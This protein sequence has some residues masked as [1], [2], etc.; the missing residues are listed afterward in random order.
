M[1]RQPYFSGNYGSALGQIDTRPI[2]QGAAAQAA[3][4]QGL[5]QNI[6]GAIEKYQL[7]KQKADTADMMIGAYLQNMSPADRGE[8]EAG[9]SEIGK[10]LNKFIDGELPTSKKVA[11]A[12][13]LGVMQAQAKTAADIRE[14]EAKAAYYEGGGARTPVDPEKAMKVDILQGLRDR[15]NAPR[16]RGQ[17][18]RGAQAPPGA[19]GI[20]GPGTGSQPL[21]VDLN[22]LIASGTQRALG[23]TPGGGPGAP[24]S[25]SAALPPPGAAAPAPT[26][27][28]PQTPAVTRAMKR[29]SRRNE[30]S[31]GFSDLS[32]GEKKLVREY[33]RDP[34]GMAYLDKEMLGGRLGKI[35]EKQQ[36]HPRSTWGTS[37]IIY[38]DDAKGKQA[39]SGYRRV[40]VNGVAEIKARPDVRLKEGDTKDIGHR[41]YTVVGGELVEHLYG[42]FDP[43][44]KGME[45]AQLFAEPLGGKPVFDRQTNKINIEFPK[46]W[47]N[48]LVTVTNDKGKPTSMQF[49]R[50]SGKILTEDKQGVWSEF[51]G[52]GGM[53]TRVERTVGEPDPSKADQKGYDSEGRMIER[54]VTFGSGAMPWLYTPATGALIQN[55]T[56]SLRDEAGL[57]KDL[58]MG[59]DAIPGLDEY[60]A[61]IRGAERYIS[62]G[63]Q[64]YKKDASGTI[65]HYAYEGADNNKHWEPFNQKMEDLSIEYMKQAARLS[66]VR[67][68]LDKQSPIN[69]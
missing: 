23:A 28:P 60:M 33:E 13:A 3:M 43:D 63:E 11:F 53:K 64:G 2:M 58:L 30:R 29:R 9:T 38:E 42:Q 7:N 1:A 6:G 65:T 16:T 66:S 55:P 24:W 54:I 48:Q 27:M 25:Q 32:K 34:V 18:R 20:P 12:G 59:Y 22:N 21:P 5:G 56:L 61:A 47:E 35:L 69:P 40:I 8:L 62:I 37:E 39:D 68:R 31:P 26:P 15:L 45:A 41:K 51:T 67:R 50:P 4:Y 49:H 44:A 17:G 52:Q 10:T 57:T 14:T 36:L 46:G 19:P